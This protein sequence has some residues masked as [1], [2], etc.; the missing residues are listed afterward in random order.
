M[1]KL[2]LLLFDWGL[3]EFNVA[4]MLHKQL[5]ILPISFKEV[6]TNEMHSHNTLGTQM[7]KKAEQGELISQELLD[8]LVSQI[9][10]QAPNDIILFQYPRTFEQYL[11]F[12][13]VLNSHNI[14]LE[15]LWYF[16]QRNPEEFLQQRFTDAQHKEWI[17]KFGEEVLQKWRTNY[18]K[19]S[20]FINQV[21]DHSSHIPT[22]VI[23][24]D[25]VSYSEME[26]YLTE[27]IKN[28]L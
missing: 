26:D 2:S 28:A 11:S 20:A 18:P 25:Y 23:E 17:E 27:K 7:R 8:R 14:E 19:M 21:L 13:K 1:K 10:T 9:L 3:S 16:K 5:N 12:L 6:I 4:R 15:T 24:L 22:K